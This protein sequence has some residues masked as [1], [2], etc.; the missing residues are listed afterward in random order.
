MRS[1]TSTWFE[2]TVR[3]AKMQE[4]GSEK[5]VTEQYAVDALSFTE[6]E[7]TILEKMTPY[8][9]GEYK[10]TG[11]KP[12]GYHEVF[13]SDK[14]GDGKWYKAKVSFVTICEATGKVK[15]SNITY[16][17]QASTLDTAVRN[18]N[19]VMSGSMTDYTS[20]SVQETKIMDVFER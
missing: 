19:D 14:D 3:Y 1:K 6:A 12:A 13:F 15:R 4:D 10:I 20:V 2:V 11:I 16:L 9:S 7:K 8:I 18:I 5:S 17:V